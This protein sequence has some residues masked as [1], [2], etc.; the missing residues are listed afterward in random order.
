MTL[1]QE[2]WRGEEAGRQLVLALCE[3]LRC[4]STV[5]EQALLSYHIQLGYQDLEFHQCVLQRNQLRRNFLLFSEDLKG[6]KS[7]SKLK[8]KIFLSKDFWG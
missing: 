3:N 6:T 1:L 8:V 5:L 4:G 7:W 2:S